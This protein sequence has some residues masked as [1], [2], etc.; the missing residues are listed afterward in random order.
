VPVVSG[1]DGGAGARSEP[2]RLTVLGC[3]GSYPGPGEACS[4]YLLRHRDTTV[5]LDL[6]PGTLAALQEHVPIEALD[7][8][9]LSHAHADHWIDLAVLRTAWKYTFGRSGL[10][11]YGTAQNRERAEVLTDGGIAPTLAWHDLHDALVADVGS[12]RFTFSPTQHYVETFAVR[13]EPAGG[14]RALGYSADTG[15]GWSYREFGLPEHT[16]LCEASHLADQEPAGI[17]HLS[18][19]QAGAMCR[20]AAV[21]R[22]VL[23]H[24]VP[25]SDADVVRAEGTAA[26]GA[27]VD[28]ARPHATYE[29]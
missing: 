7:A 26:F 12:L 17:L 10:P 18:A 19:R 14:G 4:G 20:A 16:A 3:S 11:V 21:E 23:T 27:T 22:V 29:V 13:V 5:A 8:V 24:L 2:I 28:I 9:V 15:P 1:A 25:G 6:G